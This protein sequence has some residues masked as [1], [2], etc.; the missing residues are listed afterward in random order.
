MKLGFGLYRHMLNDKHYRFAKQCGATHVV[1]HLVDYFNN[2]DNDKSSA[3][4][5]IGN[6]EGWGAAGDGKLWELDFLLKLKKDIN[7]T[8]SN[9]K[10]Q[11]FNGNRSGA[12]KA[13]SEFRNSFSDW[14]TSMKYET[15]NYKIWIGDFKTRLEADRALLKVKKKFG[16]AFIFKP[17]KEKT[18]P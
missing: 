2:D 16:I 9:Y 10:I 4:Q 15:P 14:S 1:V 6:T 18:N 8:E 3:N 12:E 17:K 7:R 11:I 5:P 13:R